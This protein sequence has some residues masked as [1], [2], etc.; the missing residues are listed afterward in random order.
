M[1]RRHVAMLEL[2]EDQA[3]AVR[4]E[5]NGQT[6]FGSADAVRS[7]VLAL[8]GSESRADAAVLAWQRDRQDQELPFQ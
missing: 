2:Y 6:N 4:A 3:A 1:D 7:H 8:T 5:E